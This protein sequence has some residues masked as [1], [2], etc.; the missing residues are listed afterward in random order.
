MVF[1]RSTIL[2][3]T[4]KGSGVY[5]SEAEMPADLR[6]QLVESTRGENSGVILIADQAGRAELEKAMQRLPVRDERPAP[7]GWRIRAIGLALAAGVALV[8]WFSFRH[9]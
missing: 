5:R 2:V 6:A 7:P 3:S 9:W 8:A 4:D 1:K